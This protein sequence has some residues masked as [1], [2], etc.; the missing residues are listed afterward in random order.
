[1][2]IGSLGAILFCENMT[3]AP[4]PRRRWLRF[5]FEATIVVG[6]FAAVS[7]WQ[8]RGL[9]TEG[10]APALALQSLDG[11]IVRLED[12]RDKTL[13][14]HFWAT[15][16]GVCRVEISSLNALYDRLDRDEV[17]L[18]VV[19]DADDVD[20]VRRF[21]AERGIR[22]PVLLATREVLERYHVDVFPTNYFIAPGGT[23]RSS[24]VGMSTRLSLATR[25]SCAAR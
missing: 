23:I 10:P 14:L 18:S 7:A 22:Y 2:G 16:C 5:V 20:A 8:T 24:T 4:R 13:L 1:M 21:V 17:L 3:D 9:A 15:W 25:M 19:A 6:A 12:L 11:R